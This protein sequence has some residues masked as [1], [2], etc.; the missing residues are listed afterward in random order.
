MGGMPGMPAGMD[1]SMVQ[2]LLQDPE[3]LEALQNPKMAKA[4]QEIMTNPGAMGKYADD[5][6]VM[7]LVKKL[8]AKMG[9]A[10]GGMP[11]MSAMF[12]GMGGMDGGADGGSDEPTF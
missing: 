1:P 3:L 8:M 5:P 9:G 4:M 7:G 2:G 11:D 12:G 10:G 6:E